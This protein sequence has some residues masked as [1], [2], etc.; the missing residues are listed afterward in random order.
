M[1]RIKYLG[2]INNFKL[3]K[4]YS[5]DITLNPGDVFELVGADLA[6]MRKVMKIDEANG[7]AGFV[8]ADMYEME[9]EAKEIENEM[10]E[11]AK[12]DRQAEAETLLGLGIKELR[13][14]AKTKGLKPKAIITKVE[15]VKMILDK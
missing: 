15:L 1:A 13:E 8:L 9:E 11:E 14:I 7:N 5:K 3:G 4:A 12:N 10:E 2:K 6:L